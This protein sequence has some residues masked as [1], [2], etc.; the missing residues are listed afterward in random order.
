MTL[1]AAVAELS[2]NHYGPLDLF[3]RLHQ[4]CQSGRH[5]DAD[6]NRREHRTIRG[7]WRPQ[8]TALDDVFK[9]VQTSIEGRLTIPIG[10]AKAP[11]LDLLIQDGYRT[12]TARH[13]RD[14]H[15]SA[16]FP[17]GEIR[18]V[19]TVLHQD[20]VYGRRRRTIIIGRR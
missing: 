5:P 9:M 8:T 17:K 20:I 4:R 13:C 2:K 11:I 15:A 16:Q 7:R 12:V 14:E 6:R 3:E 18:M 10:A 1:A 19:G